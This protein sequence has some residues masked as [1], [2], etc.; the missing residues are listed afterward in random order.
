[1]KNKRHNPNGDLVDYVDNLTECKEWCLLKVA[2]C[3]AIDYVKNTC[4]VIHSNVY[5][6][7][8]LVDNQ[9]SVHHYVEPC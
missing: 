6:K 5:S 4:Y 3:A 2:Q 7:S 1:V 8:K 9:D